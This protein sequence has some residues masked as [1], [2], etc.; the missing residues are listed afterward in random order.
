MNCLFRLSRSLMPRKLLILALGG[1]VLYGCHTPMPKPQS[2]AASAYAVTAPTTAIEPV[3]PRQH[4]YGH[5]PVDTLY[6]LLVAE[7]AAS[8]QVPTGDKMDGGN[9]KEGCKKVP[10]NDKLPTPLF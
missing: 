7:L 4:H 9:G 6:D 1:V 10:H 8:R 3:K 5:F 2:T